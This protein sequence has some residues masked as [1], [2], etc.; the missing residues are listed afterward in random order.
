LEHPSRN[1]AKKNWD[2]FHDDPE[3]QKAKAESEKNGPLVDKID[4][5]FMNPT[6]YSA[7]N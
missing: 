4:N 5:Y 7:L 6:A 3:W 1:E 2:A